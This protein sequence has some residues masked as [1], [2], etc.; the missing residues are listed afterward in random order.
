MP[1]A[2]KKLCS[3][4]GMTMLQRD[5]K[6]VRNSSWCG[7]CISVYMILGSGNAMLFRYLLSCWHVATSLLFVFTRNKGNDI[8]ITTASR[9]LLTSLVTPWGLIAPTRYIIFYSSLRGD[10]NYILFYQT[11]RHWYSDYLTTYLLSL[12]V[13]VYIYLFSTKDAKNCCFLR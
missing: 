2:C 10:I 6:N 3:L 11:S 12:E 1:C 5:R 4:F 7:A 8:I 9:L 13:K